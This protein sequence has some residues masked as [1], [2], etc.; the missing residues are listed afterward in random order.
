MK[1][2]Q[3]RLVWL[4]IA[5]TMVT[6]AVTA[7]SD[8]RAQTKQYTI[9]FANVDDNTPFAVDVKRGFVEAAKKYTNVKLLTLDNKRDP[10]ETINNADIAITKKVD[11]FIEY[12]NQAGAA[13]TVAEKLKAAKI[14]VMAVQV[15]VPG[16]PV[17]LINNFDAGYQ[18]AKALLEHSKKNWSNERPVFLLINMPSGGDPFI[19]RAN[20]A[21]K[22]VSE[23]MP[24]LV[25]S[26]FDTPANPEKTRSD[27]ADFLTANP[28]KKILAWVHLCDMGIAAKAAVEAAGRQSDVAMVTIGGTKAVIPVLKG[29]DK[30]IIG[31]VGMFS[32]K[33]GE[34]VVPIALDI[35]GGKQVPPV[36][37]PKLTYLTGDN[38]KQYYPD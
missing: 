17:F 2:D 18:A 24:G 4:V 13:K 27:M 7:P 10:V 35:L 33:W 8:S 37:H 26:E 14:P 31:S 30:V 9:A 16:A 5:I 15:P 6:I 12:T 21:K 38:V 22:A 25:I 34:Q 29:K 1:R 32:E 23:M 36:I 19:E 11:F 3:K 20:G 28:G